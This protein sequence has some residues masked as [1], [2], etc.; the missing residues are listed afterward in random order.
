M[1]SFEEFEK[2]DL[3]IAEIKRVEDIEGA[4]KLFKLI[5]DVGGENKQI[6]AGIKSNYSKEQLVGKHIVVVNNLQPA[7]LRGVESNGMLL[8]AEDGGLISLL[9][10]D[11]KVKTGSKIH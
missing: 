10:P 6:V 9:V 2:M 7:K 4:D 5:I 11:K 8:A 1:I 3:R